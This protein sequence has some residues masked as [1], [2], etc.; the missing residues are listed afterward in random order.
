MSIEGA[1]H[2]NGEQSPS[3]LED[4]VTHPMDYVGGKFRG[5]GG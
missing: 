5:E 3:L 2:V 4:I 1:R